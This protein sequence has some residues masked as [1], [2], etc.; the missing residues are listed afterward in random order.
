[1]NYILVCELAK[2]HSAVS[3]SLFKPREDE[4]VLRHAG[5]DPEKA[6]SGDTR[7]RVMFYVWPSKLKQ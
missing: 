7:V 4:R 5:T 1:M 2:C 6:W 3:R